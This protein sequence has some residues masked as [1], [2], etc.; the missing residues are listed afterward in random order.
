LEDV[1][2][3]KVDVVERKTIRR[4]FGSLAENEVKVAF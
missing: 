4:R 1:F 2:Q 3:R